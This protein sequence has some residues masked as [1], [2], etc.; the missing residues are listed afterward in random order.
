[1]KRIFSPECNGAF[2]LI[3]YNLVKHAPKEISD[4]L[5]NI[6]RPAFDFLFVNVHELS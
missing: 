1:M 4:H 5:C 6:L 2:I 3:E